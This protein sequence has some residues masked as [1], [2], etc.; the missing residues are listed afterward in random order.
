MYKVP[1]TIPSAPSLSTN[2]L[3]AIFL[4][5]TIFL[6]AI[7]IFSRHIFLMMCFPKKEEVFFLDSSGAVELKESI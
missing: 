7:C 3:L 1:T 5:I 2:D 6:N 4:N